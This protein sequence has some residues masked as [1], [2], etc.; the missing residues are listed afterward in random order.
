MTEFA[1]C[2]LEAVTIR[3]EPR[4]KANGRRARSLGAA[5]AI[6]WQRSLAKN[7]EVLHESDGGSDL[8][9]A[10]VLV[11]AWAVIDTE[12]AHRKT[13]FPILFGHK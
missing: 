1:T 13:A 2:V 7:L 11:S 9:I 12:S 6:K 8:A 4:A 3:P 5:N 10:V